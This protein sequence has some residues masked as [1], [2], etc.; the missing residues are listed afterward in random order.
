MVETRLSALQE[1]YQTGEFEVGRE[2]NENSVQ[3]ELLQNLTITQLTTWPGQLT[4]LTETETLNKWQWPT[5]P[6]R[7]SVSNNTTIFHRGPDQYWLVH[8]EQNDIL[9]D[10]PSSIS[11]VSDI[12][13]AYTVLRL[14]GSSAR[15][16]LAKGLAIDL[17]PS[18]FP[19]Q[20]FAYSAIHHIDVL[21]HL[22]DENCFDLY[23]PRSLAVDFYHWLTDAALEY[24]YKVS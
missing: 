15:A 23:V 22:V 18:V 4:A 5:E 9:S 14:A 21:A 11:V 2:H 19:A 16:V 12:S 1:H 10:L 6:H 8:Q 24:G 13:H 3:I 20:S 7:A 17:H